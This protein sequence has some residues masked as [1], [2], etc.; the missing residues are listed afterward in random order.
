[1]N[2][3]LLSNM[4][5][6]QSRPSYGVFVKNVHDEMKEL[7]SGKLTLCA[8]EYSTNKLLSYLLFYIKVLYLLIFTKVDVVY[9][10]FL[11]RTLIPGVIAK[12]IFR[13]KVIFNVH[14]SD[15]T[16][17]KKKNGLGH[18]LNLWAIKFCDGLIIPSESFKSIILADTKPSFAEQFF[19]SPSGGVKLP[20]QVNYDA[21]VTSP[22]RCLFV[23]RVTKTKGI[24]T[25]FEALNKVDFDVE[26]TVVGSIEEDIF[27]SLVNKRV[28][29]RVIGEVKQT[30]LPQYFEQAQLFL[31]PTKHH[32]SL[33]L[34]PIEAMSFGLPV[35]GSNYASVPEYVKHG[36]NGYL[37]EKGNS[38]QLLNFL[39]QFSELNSDERQDLSTNAVST[40]LQYSRKKVVK[41][42]LS[43]MESRSGNE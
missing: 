20:E 11:S 35:I 18:R 6:S 1:M 26:L 10:H 16:I 41:D 34:A 7:H 21:N 8:M 28:S 30:E 13:K 12:Y 43:Y 40:A 4:Y 42:L 14:S 36:V 2:I 3:L 38:D 39:V 19:V 15:Y 29:L 5:P 17:P 33:G 37:M 24:D 32:E 22:L 25:I 9:C 23:S 27:S 31:F